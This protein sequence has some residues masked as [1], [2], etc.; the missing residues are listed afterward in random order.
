[1]EYKEAIQ[2]LKD[3]NE[4]RRGG[5]V[6]HNNALKLGIAIDVVV[7]QGQLFLDNQKELLIANE[8]QNIGFNETRAIEKVVDIWIES[9]L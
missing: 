7:K 2:L 5:G 1:M 4:W 6:E 8:M 9:N 3:H